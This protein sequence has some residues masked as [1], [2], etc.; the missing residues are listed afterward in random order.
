MLNILP[1]VDVARI[2]AL[3]RE[4]SPELLEAIHDPD[5]PMMDGLPPAPNPWAAARH[6]L[7]KP[8]D[9][10]EPDDPSPPY[11]ATFLQCLT[12]TITLEGFSISMAR[13]YLGDASISFGWRSAV[14]SAFANVIESQ[15]A[16][17]A[18]V[19]VGEV[20]NRLVGSHVPGWPPSEYD[21]GG[22]EPCVVFE[23]LL[24]LF[25]EV[26]QRESEAVP[27]AFAIQHWVKNHYDPE[28]NRWRD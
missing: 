5:W 14:L 21:V 17:P 18:S 8:W 1:P 23:C 10:N 7:E 2:E 4:T 22:D 26:W 25:K 20:A 13:L 24:G 11:F 6:W 19:D 12:K 9:T 16:E 3:S 27:L 15:C 28:G